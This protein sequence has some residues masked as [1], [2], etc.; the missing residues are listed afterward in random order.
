M[1]QPAKRTAPAGAKRA[2]LPGAGGRKPCIPIF[3]R[4]DGAPAFVLSSTR[5]WRPEKACF[6]ANLRVRKGAS[7]RA[8]EVR[9][10]VPWY[11]RK[12]PTTWHAHAASSDQVRQKHEDR[13]SERGEGRRGKTK[14]KKQ[15]TGRKPLAAAAGEGKRADDATASIKIPPEPPTYAEARRG[16]GGAP[17]E[18]AADG[19]VGNK[20]M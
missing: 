15:E 3:V 10:W 2:V 11:Q 7:E 6:F 9:C 16:G 8:K 13:Q 5:R 17:D 14:K 18:M 19:V 20:V 1:Q 12:P 4:S